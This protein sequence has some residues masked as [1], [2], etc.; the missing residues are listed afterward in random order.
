MLSKEEI[1]K[2]RSNILR[3]NDIESACLIM[4]AVVFDRLVQ[5]GGRVNI[6]KVAMRQILNFIE[7]YKNKGYLDVVREKV[8]A[9]DRIIELE[10]DKQKLIE[11]LKEEG[12]QLE[13]DI[14]TMSIDTG[15]NYSLKLICE[16]KGMKQQ[17][18]RILSILKGEKH[19]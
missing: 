1:E 9:N 17:N 12:K 2:A 8:K 3:G 6:T 7:E 14:L 15:N 13:H 11:K 4:E 16:A 19:E 18:D 5:V 10:S